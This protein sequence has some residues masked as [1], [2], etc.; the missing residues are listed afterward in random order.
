M[1]N[2]PKTKVVFV[3]FLHF[4]A[5][6][7]ALV[8][9][10]LFVRFTSEYHTP[11]TI[12][13]QS[14]DYSPSLFARSVFPLKEQRIEERGYVINSRGY[15]GKEFAELKSD[16]VIRVIV[17]GGSAVF[18]QNVTDGYDWPSRI[19]SNLKGMGIERVEVINAGIP[20]HSS[21]DSVGKLFTEGHVF[22][23]DYVILYNA[24]NDIKHF[25]IDTPLLRKMR[26]Y[27][28]SKDFRVNYQGALDRMLS[29]TSQLY[30]RLRTR[31]FSWK[32]E[33]G[34]E[35]VVVAKE[36]NQQITEKGL[37][38]YKLNIEIF[39]DLARNI[40][41]TPIL[42]T[43]ARLVT[44]NSTEEETKHFGYKYHNMDHL[45]IVDAFRKSDDI[46]FS[47]AESKNVELVDASATMTGN[48]DY[49]TDAIHLTNEGS[50]QLSEIVAE[51]LAVLVKGNSE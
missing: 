29:E 2:T 26:P 9:G 11:S 33:V 14:L 38:Q 8:L 16:G 36:N 41:A 27:N 24:W 4:I 6:V 1:T 28:K 32:Y 48:P 18:D 43:Q 46:I 45:T 21:V 40:N 30:V 50:I 19:E 37:N 5:V 35:G 23:P 12:K 44:Q 49:F 39:T 42:I 17:Y 47:V 10:E 34:L 25:S 3:I 20:A 51:H 22:Q 7:I 13:K 31:Y 15:R